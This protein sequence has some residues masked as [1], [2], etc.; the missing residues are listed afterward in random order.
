M[1]PKPNR[2]YLATAMTHFDGT[3]SISVDGPF[4]QII[5]RKTSG[6]NWKDATGKILGLG[7]I[8]KMLNL[9]S[10]RV[11]PNHERKSINDN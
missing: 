2:Q 3:Y 10:Y 8:S 9:V 11:G 6:D 1:K 7:S 4:P 5:T